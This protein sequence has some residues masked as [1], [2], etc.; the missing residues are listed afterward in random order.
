MNHEEFVGMIFKGV[1]P[2]SVSSYDIYFR[3]C[4]LFADHI[5]RRK[6]R[7]KKLFKQRENLGK[8]FM[9]ILIFKGRKKLNRNDLEWLCPLTNLFWKQT[10]LFPLLLF[11]WLNKIQKIWV[12]GFQCNRYDFYSVC[13]FHLWRSCSN[14]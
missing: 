13:V 3:F 12:D 4:R 8:K 7:L 1:I 5:Q 11:A 2:R 6:R 9:Q 10:S 14:L